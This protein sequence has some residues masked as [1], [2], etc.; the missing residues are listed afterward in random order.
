MNNLKRDKLKI[1][2]ENIKIKEEIRILNEKNKNMIFGDKPL[3]PWETSSDKIITSSDKLPR[4]MCQSLICDE[5]LINKHELK[6]HM[7]KAHNR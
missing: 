7:E 3:Q 2:N 4:L 1:I 6:L 5:F